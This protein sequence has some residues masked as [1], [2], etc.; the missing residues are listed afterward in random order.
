MAS[1]HVP[2]SVLHKVG[3]AD[4]DRFMG[5]NETIKTEHIIII[6]DLKSKHRP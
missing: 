2:K 6:N 5:L 3:G 4:E 1:L